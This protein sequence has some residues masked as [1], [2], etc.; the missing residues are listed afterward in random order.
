MLV[1]EEQVYHL[2]ATLKGPFI[3]THK[4]MGQVHGSTDEYRAWLI[5][6]DVCWA[7]LGNSSGGGWGSF[8]SHPPICE[9]SIWQFLESRKEK[10]MVQSLLKMLQI[11][12]L[13][14]LGHSFDQSSHKASPDLRNRDIGSMFR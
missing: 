14:L 6:V 2:S 10:G 13:I 11:Y 4:S 3:I 5:L 1:G 12:S 7:W 9:P 8:M